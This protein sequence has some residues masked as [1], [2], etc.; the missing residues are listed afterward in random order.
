MTSVL[1]VQPDIPPRRPLHRRRNLLGS[2]GIDN[3]TRILA[4]RA[5]LGAGVGIASNTGTVRE[6]GR[7]GVIGP[8][9]VVD[10]S[11]VFQ[12]ERRQL[13]LR[14]DVIA[15]CAVVVGFRVVAYR[16]RGPGPDQTAVNR[17][18]ERRP[19]VIA[20]PAAILGRLLRFR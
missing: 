11:R 15:G 12:V 9:G 3:V 1:D 10:A 20:G 13:P 7:A 5:P 14:Q 6:N 8:K 2:R 17:R 19:V 16:R 4:Q 18:V